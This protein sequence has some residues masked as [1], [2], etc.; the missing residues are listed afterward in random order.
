M[1]TANRATEGGID[2]DQKRQGIGSDEANDD[3]DN[4]ESDGR[5]NGND[6]KSISVLKNK[7]FQDYY[8]GVHVFCLE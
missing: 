3:S 5:N 1:P 4:S 7:R 6:C 2:K 8:K